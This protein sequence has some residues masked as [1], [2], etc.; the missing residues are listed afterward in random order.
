MEHSMSRGTLRWGLMST[1]RINERMI[2][3]IRNASRCELVA[4]ASRRRDTAESFA[5]KWG[6]PQACVGYEA[7]LA[8]PGID[9]V[10]IPLPNS[11]HEEWTVRSAQAGKHVLCEKP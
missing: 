1:A 10:Y 6:I 7:L 8:E 9:V 11:A 3:A 2:P 5:A 4:V